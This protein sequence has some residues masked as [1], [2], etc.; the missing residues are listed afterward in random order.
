[1]GESKKPDPSEPWCMKC[2]AHTVYHTKERRTQRGIVQ[3][4]ICNNCNGGLL[5]PSTQFNLACIFAFLAVFGVIGVIASIMSTSDHKNLGKEDLW[6]D[7]MVTGFIVF[8]TLLFGM[9]S[10]ATFYLYSKWKKWARE[11]GYVEKQ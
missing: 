1:M 10:G 9:V 6:V 3:D 11:N 2:R 5:T 8:M 4:E 7:W